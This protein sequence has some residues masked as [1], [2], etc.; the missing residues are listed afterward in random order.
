MQVVDLLQDY[1]TATMSLP[2]RT[3]AN[4]AAIEAFL[5]SFRGLVQTVDLYHFARPIPRGTMRGTPTVEVHWGGD[6]TIGILTTPG[7]TLEAGD[8]IGASGRL[9]QV[10]EHCV[11]DGSGHLIAP[12]VNRLSKTV[13]A[14]GAVT[15]DKPTAA[16]RLMSPASVLHVPGYAEGVSLDFIEDVTL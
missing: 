8:M 4:A 14:G 12:I 10:A 16:F 9:L 5:N 1:W 6:S 3:R 15:W 7:A 2:P 11:A 13:A